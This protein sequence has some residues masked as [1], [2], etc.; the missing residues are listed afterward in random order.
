MSVSKEQ[1]D[2]YIRL[3]NEGKDTG[4]SDE[5]YD[6]LLEEYLNEHGES[7]RPYL[8]SEQ[9]DAVN[10]LVCT[11]PKVYNVIN[12]MREGQKT[13]KDWVE[14]KDYRNK[15]IILQPKFDGCSVGFDFNS[16]R[17]FTRGDYNNGESIDI[18]DVFVKSS[19]EIIKWANDNDPDAEGIKFE[20]IL[21]K[22]LFTNM[23]NDNLCDYKR[24]RDFVA[25]TITSRDIN[26]AE[27]ISLISLR[28]IK[29]G[30]QHIPRTLTESSVVV[31]I[32]DYQM[33]NGFINNIIGNGLQYE[34][35]GYNYAVDGVV[36]TVVDDDINIID[37]VAI[38]IIKDIKKTKLVN[39]EWQLGKSGKITP[40]AILE[41]VKFGKVTVDH[42]TLSTF[43]RVND[44]K[45][46][47]ND[48]VSIMYNI[49]PYLVDSDH[50]GSITFGLIDKCP[51][52]KEELD[53]HN[54]RTVRCTNPSCSGIK[55]GSI[56]RYCEQMKFFGVSERTICTLMEN[57]IIKDIPDLYTMTVDD[58]KD[59]EG[60]GQKSAENII[61]SIKDNSQNVPIERWLGALPMFS[62]SDK[63]WR[64][65]IDTAFNGDDESAIRFLSRTLLNDDDIYLGG[66]YDFICAIEENVGRYKNIG[67]NKL[68]NVNTGIILNWDKMKLIFP[69][70]TFK[71]KKYK[72]YNGCIAMT[73]TRDKE[74]QKALEEHDWLVKD[75]NHNVDYL[76]I[77]KRPFSSNKTE[78]AEL[79]GIPI[80]TIDECFEMLKENKL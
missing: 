30:K 37:E 1:L 66:K 24:P 77:P 76:I 16:K 9:T 63:T 22:E 72:S 21:A 7:V 62:T 27:H 34:V 59:I 41:P 3:Y 8:R 47:L 64:E 25:A 46:R 42:A 40:V 15:K 13:Y 28:Y 74:L 48:T 17:F 78:Q 50:D 57:G 65:I 36:A 33:I 71:F 5:E 61:N 14:S 67:I 69:F 39:I 68:K 29:D 2:E 31:N 18:T 10:S 26:K 55:L 75:F 79:H 80:I 73:G 60:F 54:L 35:N 20:A 52:C 6:K 32:D 12:P 38:K 45:L 4:I 44:L 53:I 43:K 56:V 23:I 19:D 51:L 11:L 58:I 70:I 49:V